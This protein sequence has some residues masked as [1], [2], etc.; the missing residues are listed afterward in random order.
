MKVISGSSIPFRLVESTGDIVMLV[1]DFAS[2]T[3]TSVDA[4]HLET[5]LSERHGW[6]IVGTH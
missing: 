2:S 6:V 5:I 1:K 4:R 3:I